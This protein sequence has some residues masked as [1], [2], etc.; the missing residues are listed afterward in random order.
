M[1]PVV[2]QNAPYLGKRVF[3]VDGNE[4]EELCDLIIEHVEADCWAFVVND[5]PLWNTYQANRSYKARIL[6]SV[7]REAITKEP[8]TI[9]CEL[10]RENQN[11]QIEIF[12]FG[13]NP[14]K[15]VL[16][17]NSQLRTYTIT[18]KVS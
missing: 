17:F 7:M 2:E 18:K 3:S 13:D 4:Y 16:D 14:W 15:L 12:M 8:H 1:L 6:A 5:E 9:L 10:H 11:S